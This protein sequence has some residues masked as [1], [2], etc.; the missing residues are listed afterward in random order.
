MPQ[1]DDNGIPPMMDDEGQTNDGNGFVPAMP[2]KQLA[3]RATPDVTEGL[4]PAFATE[5]G[6][7]VENKR[8]AYGYWRNDPNVIF[9]FFVP[10]FE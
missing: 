8:S 10:R 1:N 5:K 4:A 9:R 6:G 7:I 3:Y 2:G